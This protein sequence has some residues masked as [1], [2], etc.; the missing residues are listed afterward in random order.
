MTPRERSNLRA[1]LTA[2]RDEVERM[3][4]PRG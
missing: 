4:N 3:I 1:Q 2:L